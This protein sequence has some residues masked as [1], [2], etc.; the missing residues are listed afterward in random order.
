MR[1]LRTA[2]IATN[3]T[4]GEVIHF[5]SIQQAAKGGFTYSSVRNALRTGHTH[6]GFTFKPK[7]KLRPLK[8]NNLVTRVARLRNKGMRNKDIAEKL[9]IQR[10]TVGCYASIAH[11][12]G[13]CLT[14][15]ETMENLECD[16]KF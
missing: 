5:P 12:M 4:T 9:N 14:Y 7:G 1:P 16:G 15:A 6:A 11:K 13:L 10:G 3:V 2:V 8:V